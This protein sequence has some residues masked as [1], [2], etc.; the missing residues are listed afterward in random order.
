MALRRGGQGSTRT[1]AV[2]LVRLVDRGTAGLGR[3]SK[4]VLLTTVEIDGQFAI[5]EVTHQGKRVVGAPIGN[6]GTKDRDLFL[7]ALRSR[8][9]GATEYHLVALIRM[10]TSVEERKESRMARHRAEEILVPQR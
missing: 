8:A 9:H 6:I 5:P 4:F 2:C 3:R 1:G 7:P 10:G